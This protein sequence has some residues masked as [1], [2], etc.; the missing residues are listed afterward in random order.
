MN[1]E[2]NITLEE[3]AKKQKSKNNICKKLKTETLQE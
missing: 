2:E 3:M 1:E